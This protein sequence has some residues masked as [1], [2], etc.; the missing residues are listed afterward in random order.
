MNAFD[1]FIIVLFIVAVLY[2]YRKGIIVQI[3]SLGGVL[4]GIICCHLFNDALTSLI[5]PLIAEVESL[6]SVEY[7]GF[8]IA[9]VLLFLAGFLLMGLVAGAL[10]KLVHAL[11]LGI[12]DNVAGAIFSVF[13]WFL[14]LSLLLNVWQA[15][16]PDKS[17]L[18]SSII[19]HDKS[20]TPVMNLAPAMLVG[21]TAEQR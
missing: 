21:D 15:F 5:N 10:K 12:F 1:I 3:G 14:A 17:I 19:N 20:A 9:N 4:A 2:G 6:K 11:C 16:S 8:V 18:N 13:A 7:A